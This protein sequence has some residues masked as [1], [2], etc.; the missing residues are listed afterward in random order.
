KNLIK[1][2]IDNN[3]PTIY[4][5]YSNAGG[6]AW[7]CDGY[8][9]DYFHMNWGWGGSYNGYFLIDNLSPGSSNFY[10][11]HRLAY[12]LYPSGNYPEYCSS[13]TQVTGIEGTFNDG[14]GPE[15]YQDNVD[16]FWEIVPECGQNI[17]LEF[18]QFDV[19]TGDT[20][21]IYAGLSTSDELLVKLSDTLEIP[22]ELFSANGGMLLNFISNSNTNAGGW[23]VSYSVDFC[24]GERTITNDFGTVE[25]GSGTC[26]YKDASLCRWYIEPTGADSISIDFSSFDLSED[27]DN[28]KIFQDDMSNMLVKFNHLNPPHPVTVKSGKAI[29]YFFSNSSDNSGGWSLNYQAHFNPFSIQEEINYEFLIF[30]NPVEDILTV[31][32]STAKSEKFEISI[33]NTMG[34][35]V[36]TLNQEVS[37]IY[38]TQLDL[39][40]IPA[41]IYFVQFRSKHQFNTQKFV[42]Q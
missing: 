4:V 13:L 12:N 8:Q 37:G 1:N 21:Y 34:Q 39:S 30:P 25:D 16:C 9:N 2:E 6:H 15:K 31:T 17:Y 41:G 24:K 7:N 32:C 3:R 42:K 26:N 22:Q 33:V 27:I 35:V 23:T 14:S 40:D 5:G 29:V 10:S 38:E 18:D 36:Q 11:G 19:N 20:L 28:V